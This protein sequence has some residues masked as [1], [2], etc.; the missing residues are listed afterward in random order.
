MLI[1]FNEACVKFRKFLREDIS[2]HQSF[3]SKADLQHYAGVS[4]WIFETNS[5][6]DD[7]LYALFV[8]FQKGFRDRTADFSG[9]Q[10]RAADLLCPL[11]DSVLP[12]SENDMKNSSIVFFKLVLLESTYK[13]KV[14]YY[15]TFGAQKWQTYK[16]CY[17]LS[18]REGEKEWKST[19]VNH[20]RYQARRMLDSRWTTMQAIVKG[21]GPKRPTVISRAVEFQSAQ[22]LLASKILKFEAATQEF[23]AEVSAGNLN[24][25]SICKFYIEFELLQREISETKAKNKR[26][27][28][29]TKDETSRL[30]EEA[31]TGTK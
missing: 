9:M 7:E 8:L 10:I 30:I 14:S 4:R 5:K 28:G 18:L 17:P 26:F 21:K 19:D 16:R 13:I 23:R 11:Y 31:I 1:D 6:L 29:K 12:T 25:E 27:I 20:P 15:Y 3:P 2:I 22:E 24:K